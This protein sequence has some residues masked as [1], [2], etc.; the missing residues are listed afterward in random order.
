M[1][2]LVWRKS[3]RSSG[4]GT[5]CVEVALPPEAAALRD[6]KHRRG[7]VLVVPRASWARLLESVARS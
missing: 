1:A 6:S 7:P 2:E 4:E 5:E 3:S